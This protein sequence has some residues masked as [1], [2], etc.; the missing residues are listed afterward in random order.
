MV[1]SL[2]FAE[3]NEPLQQMEPHKHQSAAESHCGKQTQEYLDKQA[4]R[5]TSHHRHDNQSALPS[6]TNTMGMA[7]CPQC[8]QY[9]LVIV[10]NYG[11]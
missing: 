6:A 7:V 1:Q 8:Y 9:G 2:Y 11:P 5:V 3:C 10:D 4:N